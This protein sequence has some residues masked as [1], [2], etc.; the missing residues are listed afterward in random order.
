MFNNEDKVISQ[1]ISNEINSLKKELIEDYSKVI[2][3]MNDSG[4]L[5]SSVVADEI[6]KNGNKIIDSKVRIIIDELNKYPFPIKEKQWKFVEAKLSEAI[7]QIELS[8]CKRLEH[9]ITE[10]V[11]L[12]ELFTNS[13]RNLESLVKENILKSR[14]KGFESKAYYRVVS[15]KI[16][17][18][19]LTISIISIIIATIALFMSRR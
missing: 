3:D 12:T 1:F 17:I 7:G 13:K 9:I 11:Y 18:A 16:S 4:M 14:T 6:E 8:H 2:N 19:A 10:K 15:K 5:Y